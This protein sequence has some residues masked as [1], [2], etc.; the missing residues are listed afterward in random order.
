MIKLVSLHG[1]GNLSRSLLPWNFL[2]LTKILKKILTKFWT[3]FWQNSESWLNTNLVVVG[4]LDC[5]PVA[6]EE[7]VEAVV[8]EGKDDGDDARLQNVEEF[9]Q[10][11]GGYL[12]SSSACNARHRHVERRWR[13]HK[14]GRQR[15]RGGCQRRW[16]GST[17]KTHNSGPL[18]HFPPRS[19]HGQG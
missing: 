11:S 16:G 9:D 6:D 12:Q 7:D 17:A 3:K 19:A 10:T 8:Q 13:I 5:W 4:R 14:R 15:G 1:L 18:N 2:L